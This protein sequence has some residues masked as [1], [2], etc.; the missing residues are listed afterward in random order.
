MA[1]FHRRSSSQFELLPCSQRFRL[2]TW[3]LLSPYIYIQSPDKNL[4]VLSAALSSV[5][6]VHCGPTKD[7]FSIMEPARP[8]LYRFLFLVASPQYQDQSVFFLFRAPASLLSCN[9][10]YKPDSRSAK[11]VFLALSHCP[12]R[13]RRVSRSKA[14]AEVEGAANKESALGG[15]RTHQ[16]MPT[17]ETDDDRPEKV[18]NRN[19]A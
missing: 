9:R 5:F 6:S 13:R 11:T 19:T 2:S 8:L 1:S 7:F 3:F 18:K 17:S 16:A 14:R 12:H 10:R 4:S 15:R